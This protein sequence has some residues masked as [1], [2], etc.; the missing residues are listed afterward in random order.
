MLPKSAPEIAGTTS[1]ELENAV[2]IKNLNF[3]YS[4]LVQNI[5][6]FIRQSKTEVGS[7]I[8]RR[9]YGNVH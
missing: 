5:F 9:K 7:C 3:I 2:F 1:L 8:G 4:K 6:N